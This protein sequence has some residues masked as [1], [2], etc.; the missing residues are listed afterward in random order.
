[1]TDS[2][3]VAVAYFKKNP[4]RIYTSWEYPEVHK[5]GFLFSFVCKKGTVS[6]LAVNYYSEEKQ[7]G[8]PSLIHGS[9]LLQRISGLKTVFVGQTKKLTKLCKRA[10]L[11][12]DMEHISHT[13]P[14][15][16]A[17]YLEEFARV[18]RIIDKQLK[19]KP[20]ELK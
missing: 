2:Y 17:T 11:P 3:D 15:L 8:C 19:R 13:N 10:D 6:G 14:S 20:P 1:M 4:S 16:A 5:Y 18:Q 7:I 9:D 12:N